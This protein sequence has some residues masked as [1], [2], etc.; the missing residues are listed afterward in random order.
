MLLHRADVNISAKILNPSTCL[1]IRYRTCICPGP[2]ARRQRPRVQLRASEGR[3]LR[4]HGLRHP[5]GLPNLDLTEQ[6]R[7]LAESG[8]LRPSAVAS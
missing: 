5:Q 1:L 7:E 3:A 6:L 8:R 2:R 4:P